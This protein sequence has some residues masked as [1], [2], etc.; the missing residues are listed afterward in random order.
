MTLTPMW[1][2]KVLHDLIALAQAQQ[3]VVDED[4]GELVADGPVQQGRHHRGIDPPGE[5]QQDL[6][7]ADLGADLGDGLLDDVV[8]GPEPGAAA[9]AVDEALDDALALAGVGDL[10]VELEPVEAAVLVGDP[11]ERG[12]GGLADGVEAGRQAIH[13]VAVAHPDIQ[14]AIALGAGAVLDVAQQGRVAAGADL[15]IAVL[16]LGCG[17]DGPAELGGHGLHPVTDAEHRDAEVEDDL[18]GAGGLAP[19]APTQARR[20][21]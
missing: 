6:V 18:G 10:G 16:A 13:P 4:A 2:A 1:R 8:R 7:A 15:G 5:A 9:D 20:R 3:A 21:G 11:G 17:G 12:V 14:Q 19:R